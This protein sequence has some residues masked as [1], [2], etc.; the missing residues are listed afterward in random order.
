MIEDLNSLSN[1]EISNHW[2]ELT[3]SLVQLSEEAIAR[4]NNQ[5][6]ESSV[7]D[8]ETLIK[9]TSKIIQYLKALQ[10]IPPDENYEH[11]DTDNLFKKS[12]QKKLLD[13]LKQVLSMSY[14]YLALSCLRQP[15][16]QFSKAVHAYLSALYWNDQ[17]MIAKEAVLSCF[18]EASR[19]LILETL[20]LQPTESNI[21]WANFNN[22]GYSLLKQSTP[23]MKEA[24][25]AFN[26]SLEIQNRAGTY[27]GL[28]LALYG[29]G[30]NEEALN[31]WMQVKNLDENYNFELSTVAEIVETEAEC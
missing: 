5:N 31:A 27:Y 26:N 17:N 1:D 29:L 3:Q 11:T 8:Y 24:V 7:K 20:S 18:D 9:H 16:T 19:F 28:G 21:L 4:F 23:D 2:Q 22:L 10:T 14:T 15:E 13:N 6:F 12:T 25:N 30:M